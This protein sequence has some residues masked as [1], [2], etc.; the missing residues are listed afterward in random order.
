MALM[1]F[2]FDLDEVIFQ[3]DNAFAHTGRIVQ[4]WFWKQ[5]YSVMEWVV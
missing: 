4:E 1:D 2:D 3:K 5:S